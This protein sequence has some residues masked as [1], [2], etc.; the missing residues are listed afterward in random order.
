MFSPSLDT[1]RL[2]LHVVAASVWVGGQFVMAGLVPTAR[3]IAPDAVRPLAQAFGRVAWPAFVV[4]V[5]TGVWNLM[6]VDVIN[7]SGEYVGTLMVKILVAVLSGVFA[8]V[9]SGGRSKAALAIGGA[10]GALTSVVAMFLGIL[11]H[12]HA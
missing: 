10:L 8:V 11:L 1:L 4:T 2:F 12:A 6:A 5:V 3:R 9:H 7:A